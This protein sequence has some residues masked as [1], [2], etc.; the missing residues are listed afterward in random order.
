MER[1]AIEAGFA[2]LAE[3]I[4]E[5]ACV[6]RVSKCTGCECFLGVVQAIDS[7]LAPIQLPQASGFRADLRAW[8]EQGQTRPH[9]C[10]GC[11]VCLPVEP[12]NQFV[13]RF[14]RSAARTDSADGTTCAT[15]CD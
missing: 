13:T 9:G 6:Q 7:K 12:Y 4:D 1:Q 11:A 8:L 2:A 5:L 3:I 10:L 14:S 15:S